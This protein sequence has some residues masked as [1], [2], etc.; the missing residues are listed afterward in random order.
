MAQLRYETSPC[1]RD[2]VRLPPRLDVITIGALQPSGLNGRRL[3]DGGA[4]LVDS[5]V[6]IGVEVGSGV[7][8]GVGVGVG[9]GVKVGSG[10]KVT[11]GVG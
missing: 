6:G 3:A 5:M 11:V 4:W 9:V 10:V 1:V 8:V 7:Q 2:V